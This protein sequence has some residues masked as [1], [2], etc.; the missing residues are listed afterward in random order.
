[1]TK[2][3]QAEDVTEAHILTS[4]F[5]DIDD[6]PVSKTE[7]RAWYL[8]GMGADPISFCQGISPSHRFFLPLIVERLAADG[9]FTA[10]DHTVPC[11]PSVAGYSC[12][13]P[14]GGAWMDTSSFYFMTVV[15]STILQLILFIGMGSIADHGPYRKKFMLGFS[16]LGSICCILFMA[17]IQKTNYWFSAVLTILVGVA[18]GSAWVFNYAFIPPLARNH[19]DFLEVA[20]TPGVTRERLLAK[21]DEVT[22]YISSI[23][24]VYMYGGTLVLLVVI[25]GL[26]FVLPVPDSFPSNYA[27][28]V[29]V[30][31]GGLIWLIGIFIAWKEMRDRPGPAFPEGENVVLFSTKK[32]FSAI[33]QARKLQNLFLFLIGWFCY[34]DGLA[35]LI[36]ATVLW[37]NDELGFTSKE[38]LILAAEVPILALIGSW[39][40]NK[41]QVKFRIPSK[42]M[43]LIQNTVYTLIVLWGWLGFTNAGLG[44]KTKIELYAAATLHGLLLGGTQSTCR[45]LFGQLLPAGHESKFFALYEI[46]DKG[47]AWIGP[48]VIAAIRTS[49]T[50]KSFE[51]VFL[52]A[53]FVVGLVLFSRVDV[54]AGVEEGKLFGAAEREKEESRKNIA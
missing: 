49:G 20:K 18:L 7:L 23:S 54:F 43:L 19:P 17:I 6:T 25:V 46:V 14:V 35:T 28:H 50:N 32:V 45:A 30:G 38:I 51:F 4:E 8:F 11:D 33:S 5:K 41:A 31:L 13:V 37:A 39:L 22:N 42:T 53:Q 9:G 34:S 12:V 21:L 48:L 2:T 40:W 27:Y 47:S 15:V 1:M 24:F 44:Y 52:T 16:V 10:A 26:N 29:G 3:Q 36:A